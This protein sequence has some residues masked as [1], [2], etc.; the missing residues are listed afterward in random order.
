MQE[1]ET[2]P[3]TIEVA[4]KAFINPEAFEQERRGISETYANRRRITELKLDDDEVREM[5]STNEQ[6]REDRAAWF[7]E[8]TQ[9]A[10]SEMAEKRE[11]IT[12]G[13]TLQEIIEAMAVDEEDVPRTRKTWTSYDFQFGS[14]GRVV[15][16]RKHIHHP[17]K[18]PT[19][20]TRRSLR[21]IP[22]GP[23]GNVRGHAPVYHSKKFN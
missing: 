11:M 14:D 4:E 7:T 3:R 15:E 17:H 22:S 19:E 5:E 20:K 23:T 9:L 12:D 21:A 1:V 10:V 16:I 13:M 18:I 8:L 6:N 2:T